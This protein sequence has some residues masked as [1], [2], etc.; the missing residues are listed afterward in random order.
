M[1][2]PAVLGFSRRLRPDLLAIAKPVAETH[3]HYLNHPGR[4]TVAL[5]PEVP[6]RSINN[7]SVKTAAILLSG[8][9]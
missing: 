4:C 8:V 2:H 5:Q 7:Q 6:R 3:T 1:P 9:I